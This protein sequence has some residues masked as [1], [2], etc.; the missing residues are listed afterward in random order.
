MIQTFVE[1]EF[2]STY[3]NKAWPSKGNPLI[4]YHD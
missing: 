3:E 1:D 4:L 2:I